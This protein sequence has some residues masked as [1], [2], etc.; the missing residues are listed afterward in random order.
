MVLKPLQKSCQNQHLRARF[1]KHNCL[2]CLF[3][4]PQDVFWA[5]P[6]RHKW[7]QRRTYNSV[8][9]TAECL[10]SHRSLPT[11]VVFIGGCTKLPFW[12]KT[13][14]VVSSFLACLGVTRLGIALNSS[15]AQNKHEKM[16]QVISTGQ[17]FEPIRNFLFWLW[18]SFSATLPSYFYSASGR[19]AQITRI[20]DSRESPLVV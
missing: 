12:Q 19:F 5:R 2:L 7:C 10:D 15:L 18:S 9:E 13:S 6:G 14:V 8:W 20:S 11:L 3:I 1:V 17:S 16:K 4:T